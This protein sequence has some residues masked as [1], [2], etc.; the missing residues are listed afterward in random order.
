MNTVLFLLHCLVIPI[1]K[2]VLICE[3]TCKVYNIP[4]DT[5]FREITWYTEYYNKFKKDN[6]S[7]YQ[8]ICI[9]IPFDDAPG[10]VLYYRTE[11]HVGLLEKGTTMDIQKKGFSS[12]ENDHFEKQL[13]ETEKGGF[14]CICDLNK[15]NIVYSICIVKR[16]EEIVFQYQGLNMNMLNLKDKE[17]DKLKNTIQLVRSLK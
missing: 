5:P 17:R 9:S 13:G 8:L 16:K 1:D 7:E 3:D 2:P 11:N 15:I 4:L 14:V 10:Q 6:Q 12:I